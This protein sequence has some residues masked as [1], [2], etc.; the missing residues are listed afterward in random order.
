M[1]CGLNPEPPPGL[2]TLLWTQRHW[3]RVAVLLRLSFSTDVGA[4]KDQCLVRF[5]LKDGDMQS[6]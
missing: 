6:R 5:L 1:G 3:V 2:A 4:R